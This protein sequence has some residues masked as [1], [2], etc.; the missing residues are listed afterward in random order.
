VQAKATKIVFSSNKSVPR[1]IG[2]E[3]SQSSNLIKYCVAA[4][5][6]IILSAGALGSP[7]ILMLSGIGPQ[8]ELQHLGISIVKEL[9]AVGKNLNDVTSSIWTM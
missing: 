5:K 9:S 6:E 1:A 7:H 4:K 3:L 8:E 2:V